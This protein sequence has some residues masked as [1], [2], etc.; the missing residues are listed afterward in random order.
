MARVVIEDRRASTAFGKGNF[1]VWIERGQPFPH[2]LFG[3]MAPT[4][5][6]AQKIAKDLRKKP[7]AE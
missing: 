4:K 6:E 2:R 3:G 1:V 7:Q 5:V